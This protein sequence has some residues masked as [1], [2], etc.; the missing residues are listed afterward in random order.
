VNHSLRLL[1]AAVVALVSYFVGILVAPILYHY[2]MFSSD[3][4]AEIAAIQFRSL[5]RGDTYFGSY[6]AQGYVGLTIIFTVTYFVFKMHGRNLQILF[7]FGLGIYYNIMISG[8]EAGHLHAAFDEAISPSL[9][10]LTEMP[11]YL[12]LPLLMMFGFP[13]IVAYAAVKA[14]RG[15]RMRTSSR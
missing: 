12:V 6:A 3:T 10:V 14:E 11:M 4:M 7:F 5:A 8:A 1:T 9:P 2:K 15:A 13:L